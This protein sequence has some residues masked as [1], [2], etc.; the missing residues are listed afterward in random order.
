MEGGVNSI[1]TWNDIDGRDQP[2]ANGHASQYL[3]RIP[4]RLGRIF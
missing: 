1:F 2:R 4:S 3:I